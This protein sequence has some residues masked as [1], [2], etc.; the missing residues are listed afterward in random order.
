MFV[1]SRE[2]AGMMTPIE[3]SEDRMLGDYGAL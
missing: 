1:P 2:G 3:Y